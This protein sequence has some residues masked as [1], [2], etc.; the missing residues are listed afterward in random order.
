MEISQP[1]LD[2][3]AIGLSLVCTIHCLLTPLAIAL[4]PALG[5][6]F[7]D[8]ERFHYAVLFFVIPT[9]LYVLGLGCR[10]HGRLG[11][12]AIGMLGLLVLSSILIIGEETLGETGEKVTT[13]LGAVIVASAHIRNYRL[14]QK[15]AC[16]E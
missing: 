11:V 3:T 2:K 13:V 1:N 9:S 5:A 14:C 12:L 6:T 7:L 16:H 10:K 4:L 8:D 15:N